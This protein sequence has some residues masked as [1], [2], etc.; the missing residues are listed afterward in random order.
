MPGRICGL[1]KDADGKQG[2]V[3]TLNAREQH[4]RRQKATSNICSNQGLNMVAFTIHLA[5]LGKNGLKKLAKVNHKLTNI[6]YD[7]LSKN[8]KVKL[9]NNHYFR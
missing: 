7:K 1:T 3:L 5:L 4:I 2:F 6:L 8:P 9:I